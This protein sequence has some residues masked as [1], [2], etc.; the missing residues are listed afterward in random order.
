ME[1]PLRAFL[2]T[3]GQP[4]L[5]DGKVKVSAFST[6]LR[7]FSSGRR[8]GATPSRG[9]GSQELL[10]P[11]GH[12]APR[13]GLRRRRGGARVPQLR[14]GRWGVAATG[15][16]GRPRTRDR[17]RVV[18][19]EQASLEA[20]QTLTLHK[21]QR[22]YP[23]TDQSMDYSVLSP[24]PNGAPRGKS[25]AP[26]HGALGVPGLASGARLPREGGEPGCPAAYPASGLDGLP[27]SGARLP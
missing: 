9:D 3:S 20:S 25:N 16:T 4:F 23:L 11:R 8:G 26:S 18:V 19:S 7:R 15:H 12:R 17:G 22:E 6:R 24:C 10:L 14:R 21:R 1:A 5:W 27:E 2:S 13:E